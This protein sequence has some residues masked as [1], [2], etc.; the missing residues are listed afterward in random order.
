LPQKIDAITGDEYQDYSVELWGPLLEQL[1][2]DLTWQAIQDNLLGP[3]G[4]ANS[5]WQDEVFQ[6]APQQEYSVGISGGSETTKIYASLGF[7]DEMG[8]IKSS[9]FERFS[10]RLNVDHIIS[11]QLSFGITVYSVLLY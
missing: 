8:I 11:D 7:K 4:N 10:G 3:I 5:N 1:G 2:L 6:T 9:G